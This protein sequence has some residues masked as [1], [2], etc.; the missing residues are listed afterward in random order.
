MGIL[1]STRRFF[2]NILFAFFSIVAF[3]LLTELVLR[4]IGA[5]A[6]SKN[7][8]FQLNPELD[9]PRFFQRDR[10]LF[11]KFR[12]NQVIKSD[13]FVEGEYRINSFG[14]R[15]EEFSKIKPAGV[16]RIICLGNSN[17]FGWKQRESDAYPQ[18]LQSL[19]DA[20]LPGL[21]IEVINAGITGYSTYQGKIFLGEEILR[22]EPDLVLVNYG[23][24]DLLPAKFGIQDKEQKLPPQWVLD[25]QNLLSQTTLYQTLKSFWVGRFSGKKAIEPGI[26]RVSIDDFQNNL[27]DMEKICREYGINA[28]LLTNPIAS[29]EAYW[30]KGKVSNV[31]LLHQAYNDAI[32]QLAFSKG[33]EILDIALLFEGRR[34]LYDNPQADYI[35]YN[36]LG[37]KV[38][39]Q[40][41]YEYLLWKQFITPR[42]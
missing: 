39:A 9:Y 27:T 33:F 38:V 4:L 35:H 8:Y 41:I 25:L 36:A 29:L 6:Q 19:C 11:W 13:F 40:A 24:N 21:K 28:V 18:Q 17:T 16:F 23:W 30:G 3:L 1:L 37:H 42:S 34:D 15:N 2:L 26:S 12:P 22:L 7:L 20:K 14:L 10:D 31:H 5:P 32:R